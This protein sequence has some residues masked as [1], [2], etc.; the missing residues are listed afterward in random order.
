LCRRYCESGGQV[1]NVS[2][3]FFVHLLLFLIISHY[4]FIRIYP[5]Q[6]AN[7]SARGDWKDACRAAQ[8]VLRLIPADPLDTETVILCPV[9]PHAEHRLRVGSPGRRVIVRRLSSF[10]NFSFLGRPRGTLV[11]GGPH[12]F[13]LW[14]VR[15][16]MSTGDPKAVESES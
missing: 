12:G 7:S 16:E 3:Y 5:S 13:S 14:T 9:S 1:R 2:F 8:T 15:S 4:F 6:G 11:T 10:R